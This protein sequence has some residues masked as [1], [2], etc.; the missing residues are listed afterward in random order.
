MRIVFTKDF[1]A[2]VKFNICCMSG[3][4]ESRIN[5]FCA[6]D[7]LEV[8]A[9]EREAKVKVKSRPGQKGGGSQLCRVVLLGP[10]QVATHPDHFEIDDDCFV[11]RC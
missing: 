2:Q 10:N 7:E 8:F 5:S 3:G 9:V 6:G 11:V 4:Y 1:T